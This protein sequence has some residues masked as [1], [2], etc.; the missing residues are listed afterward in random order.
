MA[1]IF[2][3]QADAYD[4]SAKL[5]DRLFVIKEILPALAQKPE[6]VET[7]VSEAGLAARL[8]HPNIVKVAHLGY[9]DGSVY[10]AMEYVEGLDL[11]QVL[12]RAARNKVAVPVAFS[13]RVVTEILTGLEY[14][15]S[16]T[17]GEAGGERL[18]IV[19][20]DVSPSNIL[21]RFDGAVK[22]CDFGIARANA[23][24]DTTA[25]REALDNAPSDDW[26][27][28]T[29]IFR[30]PLLDDVILGKA[31]YMSPEQAKGEVVDAR[32]DV[33]AA[34]VILWELLAGRRLYKATAEHALIDLARAAE[35]P[36][37]PSL[38]LDHEEELFAV[39]RRALAR[40]PELR[41]PSAA[42]MQRD[43]E[44]YAARSGLTSSLESF[45]A[46]LMEHFGHQVV[47]D[48]RARERGMRALRLGPP[49]VLKPIGGTPTLECAPGVSDAAT[50]DSP[51]D[52]ASLADMG[53][54]R[55][56]PEETKGPIDPK[57]KAVGPASSASFDSR[58]LAYML[59]AALVAYAALWVS[60]PIGP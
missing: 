34:G 48:R 17:S 50:T 53:V 58:L 21:V 47:Q 60:L 12:R 44:A 25:Y 15:H 16:A 7:L 4:Q 32:G 56:A 59:V 23:L 9:G 18:G 11:R 1:N 45:G 3:A 52:L 24:A 38:G 31:G 5:G 41:Y 35:I 22:L 10:I 26:A 14:A 54:S 49:V 46:W 55:S 51:G 37:L 19:H 33:F 2:L 29:G 57:K 30:R 39:V 28:A 36:D 27:A 40:D 20:R 43:L 6:F 42:A 13:L 8:D